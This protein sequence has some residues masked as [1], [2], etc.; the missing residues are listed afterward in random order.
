MGKTTIEIL[1][2]LEIMLEEKGIQPSQIQDKILFM[3]MHNQF[4]IQEK[5]SK[6]ESCDDAKRVAQFAQKF[7]PRHWSFL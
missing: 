7:K 4:C 2:C 1:E 3:S 6:N 5:E